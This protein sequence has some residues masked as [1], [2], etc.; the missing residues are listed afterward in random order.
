MSDWKIETRA[1]NDQR[2]LPELIELWRAL[3]AV[4]IRRPS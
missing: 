3:S 2:G 4:M 1:M